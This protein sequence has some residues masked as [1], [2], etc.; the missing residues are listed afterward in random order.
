MHDDGSQLTR[1]S[2]Q[3]PVALSPGAI[4]GS[5]RIERLPGRGG[6]GAVFLAHDTILPWRSWKRTA[7]RKPRASRRSE[8]E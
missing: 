7:M 6:M 2:D 5:Y 1:A 8:G 3:A 4:L